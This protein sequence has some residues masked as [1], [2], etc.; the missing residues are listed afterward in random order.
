ML[1]V[2]TCINTYISA[3]WCNSNNS[4]CQISS[5][6]NISPSEG[7]LT[8]IFRWIG[9][10]LVYFYSWSTRPI[11]LKESQLH[12]PPTTNIPTHLKLLNWYDCPLPSYDYDVKKPY[13]WI[14][15]YFYGVPT[16]TKIHLHAAVF[17]T[18]EILSTLALHLNHLLLCSMNWFS[19]NAVML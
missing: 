1:S 11:V 2:R 7:R 3:F 16:T 19:L 13:T 17:I 18:H 5:E 6:R 15:L 9:E 14:C 12:L 10:P 4:L 8:L